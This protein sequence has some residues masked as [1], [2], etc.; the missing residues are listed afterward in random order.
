[1]SLC[2]SSSP[3]ESPKL[4]NISEINEKHRDN[5][6]STTSNP[7]QPDNER[8]FT[9][10]AKQRSRVKDVQVVSVIQAD[11]DE[12][13]HLINTGVTSSNINEVIHTMNKEN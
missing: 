1:M 13:T 4:D 7:I 9:K 8:Q 11:P 10:T 5:C 3:C 6:I 2:N 12:T